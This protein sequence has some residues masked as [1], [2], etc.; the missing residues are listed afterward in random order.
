MDRTCRSHVPL[1][2]LF[3][4]AILMLAISYF[5]TADVQSPRVR[6]LVEESAAKKA[7]DESALLNDDPLLPGDMAEVLGFVKKHA[8]YTSYHLLLAVRKYYPASYKEV[9]NEDKVA[10]LCSALTHSHWLNDW[11]YLDPSESYDGESAKALL[12]IGKTALKR[13][14][15]I[16]ENGGRRRCLGRKRQR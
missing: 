15:P 7:V 14:T 13:L 16:L 8:D 3:W 12:E 10:I 9:S 1:A 2:W 11:G 4:A 6:R 5:K